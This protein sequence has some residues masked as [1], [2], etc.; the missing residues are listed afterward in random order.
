V[1]PAI[2]AMFEFEI[3]SDGFSSKS[4]LRGTRDW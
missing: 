2:K 1:R 3:L 4:S